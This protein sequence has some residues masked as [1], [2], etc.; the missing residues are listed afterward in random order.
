MKFIRKF[1]RP[2][3]GDEMYRSRNRR[4]VPWPTYVVVDGCWILGPCD[5]HWGIRWETVK[6]SSYSTDVWFRRYKLPAECDDVADRFNGWSLPVKP[7][8]SNDV[9]AAC[10]ARR[11]PFLLWRHTVHARQWTAPAYLQCQIES[12]IFALCALGLRV[13]CL[14]LSKSRSE[15]RALH[16]QSPQPLRQSVSDAV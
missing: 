6:A 4:V 3:A 14:C 12:G 1:T 10:G 2:L 7:F 11:H 13:E 9:N 15:E 5:R 8:G 16:G